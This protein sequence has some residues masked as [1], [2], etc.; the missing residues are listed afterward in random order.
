MGLVIHRQRIL[1]GKFNQVSKFQQLFEHLIQQTVIKV[2]FS[3]SME[4][5]VSRTLHRRDS[6]LPLDIAPGNFS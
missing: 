1:P 3:E 6:I 5:L 4:N 2:D